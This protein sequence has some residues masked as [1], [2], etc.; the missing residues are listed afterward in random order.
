MRTNFDLKQKFRVRISG[1]WVADFATVSSLEMEVGVIEYREGGAMFPDL[2]PG[3]AKATEVTLERGVGQDADM[4]AWFT[5]VVSGAS[6]Q[7]LPVPL[8]RRD[9][10]IEQLD[11]NDVLKKAYRLFHAWPRKI[12]MGEWDANAEEVVMESITLAYRNAERVV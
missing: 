9:V 4:Y 5:Q 12:V 10:D 1:F 6:Q 2:S 11:R 8:I 3:L 7:G